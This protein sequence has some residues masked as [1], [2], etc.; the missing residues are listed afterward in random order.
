MNNY[1]LDNCVERNLESLD[2]ILGIRFSHYYISDSSDNIDK[3]TDFINY[4]FILMRTI[5]AK[6]SYDNNTS[7]NKIKNEILIPIDKESLNMKSFNVILS[8][9]E[10]KKK[11]IE[12]RY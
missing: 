8:S 5:T 1:P 4:L 11:L 3:N 12:K 6:L 2:S 10:E 9:V 7:S